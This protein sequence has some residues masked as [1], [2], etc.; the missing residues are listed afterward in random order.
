MGT[1]WGRYEPRMCPQSCSCSGSCSSQRCS[2]SKRPI[3]ISLSII[4]TTPALAS[5][6]NRA[7]AFSAIESQR[8]GQVIASDA[9]PRSRGGT[10]SQSRN[11]TTCVGCGCDFEHEHEHEDEYEDEY[12]DARWG[13]AVLCDF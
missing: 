8:D 2:C 6:F 10:N 11:A 9:N 12:E 3:T 7:P 1:D 5:Q 13:L 4:G